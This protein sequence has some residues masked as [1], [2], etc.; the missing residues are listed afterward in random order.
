MRQLWAVLDQEIQDGG[1]RWPPFI[2]NDSILRHV[3]SS[4][5][6]VDVIGD[7]FRRTIYPSSPGVLGSCYML[8][9]TEGREGE[10]ASDRRGPRTEPGLNRVN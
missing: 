6:G 1:P 2:H 4:P 9:V 10:P 7:L 3:T 8:G 5:R